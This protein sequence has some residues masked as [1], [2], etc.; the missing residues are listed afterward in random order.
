MKRLIYLIF[1]ICLLCG[2]QEGDI[3][4]D[5]ALN[6]RQKLLAG[7]GCSFVAE[8]TA[9]YGDMIYQFSMCCQGDRQG[10]LVFSVTEPESISGI[11]GT[12]TETGG[13]LTFDGTALSFATIADGQVTPVTAPWLFLKTLR[14]GYIV[15]YASVED[16]TYLQIDDSYHDKALHLD[17]WL[18]GE[19][20]PVRGEILWEGRRILSIVVKDFLIL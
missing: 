3:Q 7:N 10:N 12:I 14:S 6:F 9:D 18:D 11:T 13:H 8:I 16:S 1:I 4:M 20:V 2:C 19:N 15:S 17:I 5:M